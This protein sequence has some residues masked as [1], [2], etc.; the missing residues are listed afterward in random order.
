[1]G[2]KISVNSAT[3]MNKGL[4]LIEAHHLFGLPSER[5]D[6]VIHPQ[7]IVHSL[8]EFVDGSLLAQLGTADMRIPIAYALS[9]PE[10]M[11]TPGGAP[12]PRRAW[13]VSTS[14][15]LTCNAF[16]RSGWPA[17]RSK[18]AAA[19]AVVLNAA[20][21]IAVELFLA[22]R[23]AFPEIAAMVARRARPVTPQ[24]LRDRSRR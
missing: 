13:P 5:I 8:V 10:R 11:A 9:W 23:I 24:P 12:R 7:S 21:E 19:A 2:A 15:R 3:L 22:G 18:Q 6:V 20:N 1:M 14:K 17:K 16:R 4:E